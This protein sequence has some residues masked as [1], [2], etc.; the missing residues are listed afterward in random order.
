MLQR[1]Y[2]SV[3]SQNAF[4]QHL[5]PRSV[6]GLAIQQGVCMSPSATSIC[7]QPRPNPLPNPNPKS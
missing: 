5:H 7:N 3:T 6:G 4:F 2:N 1:G